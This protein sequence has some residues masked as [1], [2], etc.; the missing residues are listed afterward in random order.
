ME[1]VTLNNGVEMPVLGFGVYQ[2][3]PAQT[4]RAVADALAAG[5]RSLDT[6]AAYG[7][8]EAVG[9]AIRGSGIPREELFVTTKL[10]ISDAGEDR[11]GRAFETSLRKL[12]LDH[13]DLYLIHQPYGDVYGS[14][15]AMEGLQREG[16]VRAIGVSNFHG[17][18]LVDLMDHNEVAPAVNQIETH[19]FHQRTADQELMRGRGVQIE[20]WGPFAEGRGDLFTHPVLTRIA[21]AHEKSVAQVVLRWLVQRGVVVIPKSV[22]PERMAE[23]LDVF[24]FRLTD[25]QMDAVAALDTGASL[26]FDHRDPEMVSRLGNVT[27][28]V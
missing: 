1:T 27:L 20:S 23:N 22:R 10:W 6:A 14:W 4:E 24:G 21:A 18:R 12:G 19:P 25:D 28:N 5:Y 16:R 26:F 3:P 9:R 13:L 7:N 15:R 17:D 2:I 11:A 8:E